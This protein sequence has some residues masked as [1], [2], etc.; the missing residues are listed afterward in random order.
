[1]ISEKLELVKKEVEQ[2]LGIKTRIVTCNKNGVDLEGICILDDSPFFPIIYYHGEPS[3]D[4][5]RMAKEAFNQERPL[6]DVEVLRDKEFVLK[7]SRLGIQRKTNDPIL[8]KACLNLELYIRLTLTPVV[9]RR[10]NIATIKMTKELL[11]LSGLTE[12]EIWRAAK[13]NTMKF[14]E[15]TNMEEMMGITGDV[16]HLFEVVTNFD[17]MHGAVALAFPEIFRQYCIERNL[18]SVVLLPSSVHEILVLEDSDIDYMQF[19]EMVDAV[20]QA[21]VSIFERLD[22][23][24]Y[25]YDLASVYANLKLSQDVH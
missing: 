20:N 6:A 11:T 1:M 5:I 23:V 16:P 8:K 21:E 17:R 3:E 15:I 22:P 24:V 13:A 9:D 19:A 14:F 10:R 12:Y 4:F 7:H 2:E 25:R 18:E